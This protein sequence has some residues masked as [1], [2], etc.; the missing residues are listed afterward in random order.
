MEITRTRNQNDKLAIVIPAYKGLYFNKTLE[1][2]AAQTCKEFI[3]Y[4]GNDNSPEKLYEI[5]ELYKDKLEIVYQKFDENYGGSNLVNHWNRCLDLVQDEPWIWLFSDDDYPEANCV[6]LFYNS[7]NTY[8][9]YDLYRFNVQIINSLNSKIG[10][11]R[12]FP[13]ELSSSEF[14]EKRIKKEIFSYAIEYIFRKDAFVEVGGFEYFDLGW[15]TDDATWIKIAK[16]NK[17]KTIDGSIVNWRYSGINISSITNDKTI[18][19]RKLKANLEYL[20]WADKYFKSNNIQVKTNNVEKIKWL[21]TM[22]I[23]TTCLSFHEKEQYLND[24]LERLNLSH[25]RLMGYFILRTG[26]IKKRAKAFI[27]RNN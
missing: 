10:E 27:M 26:L 16:K 1:A 5:I 18:V 23:D 22:P 2:L 25:L 17:I 15:S 19:I 13:S 14:F 9:N 11:V 20:L 6:E 3:I 12:K 24:C 4:I 8:P 21:L 7:L